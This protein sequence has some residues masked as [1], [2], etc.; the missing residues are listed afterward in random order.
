MKNSEILRK[1]PSYHILLSNHRN[2]FCTLKIMWRNTGA[3][4]FHFLTSLKQFRM[5]FYYIQPFSYLSLIL[6]FLA[7]SHLI[8]GYLGH[9]RSISFYL[10]LMRAIS[11]YLR[12]ALAMSVNLWQSC[13]ILGNLWKYVA[14]SSYIWLS[15][16]F[17]GWYNFKI[18]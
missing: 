2:W 16:A 7:L 12:L 13:A 3:R 6:T 10:L 4:G 8:S 17:S 9:S 5:V 14:I 1:L 15:L 18:W 11:G